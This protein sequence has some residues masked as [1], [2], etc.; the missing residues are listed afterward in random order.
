MGTP[1][2]EKYGS[3]QS[4]AKSL[5]MLQIDADPE[6]NKNLL[7]E[8]MPV[9]L[10]LMDAL[11][12]Q[13]DKPVQWVLTFL[14]D[15]VRADSSA[16]IIFEDAL[17]SKVDIYKVLMALMLRKKTEPYILDKASLLLSS[18]MGVLPEKFNES[19][20]SGFLDSLMG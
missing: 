15:L 3:T 8:N 5:G 20:V 4:S 16:Y 14:V 6:K 17:K 13:E 7:H 18:V 1:Q 10:S 11:Q 12:I 2:W 19:Q 9:L